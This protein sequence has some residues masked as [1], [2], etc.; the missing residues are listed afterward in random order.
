MKMIIMVMGAWL[1]TKKRNSL[2]WKKL[3]EMKITTLHWRHLMVIVVVLV[4]R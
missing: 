1:S 3:P 2:L 4:V